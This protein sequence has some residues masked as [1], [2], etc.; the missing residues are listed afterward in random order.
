[1]D[2]ESCDL[3]FND[4]SAIEETICS[5]EQIKDYVDDALSN[6]RKRLGY[7]SG[8]PSMAYLHGALPLSDK[9]KE[10]H[11]AEQEKKNKPERTL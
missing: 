10:M 8:L 2:K 1:M 3:S 6:L 9:E 7:P 4:K 5:L 11:L